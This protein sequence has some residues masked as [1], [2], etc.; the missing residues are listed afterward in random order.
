MADRLLPSFSSCD[1]R[2]PCSPFSV[3]HVSG[4]RGMLTFR[5]VWWLLLFAATATSHGERT[6]PTWFSASPSVLQ[7]SQI[8]PALALRDAASEREPPLIQCAN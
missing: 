7:P 2:G 5:S 1:L 4:A 3:V 6:L 8:P